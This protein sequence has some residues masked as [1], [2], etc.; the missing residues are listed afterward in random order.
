MLVPSRRVH[1]AGGAQIRGPP[2]EFETQVVSSFSGL[3][4]SELE[5]NRQNLRVQISCT[6]LDVRKVLG[7]DYPDTHLR[8]IHVTSG[9]H[10][11]GIAETVGQQICLQFLVPCQF[12]LRLHHWYFSWFKQM[13]GRVCEGTR[14]IHPTPT[15]Q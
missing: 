3:C 2:S 14:G 10:I 15:S 9:S 11:F 7:R 13:L 12:M 4:P 8:A 6:S 1:L 5:W